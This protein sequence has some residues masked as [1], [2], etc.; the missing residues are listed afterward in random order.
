MSANLSD[1]TTLQQFQLLGRTLTL[2]NRLSLPA[3]SHSPERATHPAKVALDVQLDTLSTNDT[4]SSALA[5]PHDG[6]FAGVVDPFAYFDERSNPNDRENALPEL[7]APSIKV[8]QSLPASRRSSFALPPPFAL[9]KSMSQSELRDTSTLAHARA[10]EARGWLRASQSDPHLLATKMKS[11]SISPGPME[12][13]PKR[14][15]PAPRWRELLSTAKK[16]DYVFK[17]DLASEGASLQAKAR[18]AIDTGIIAGLRAPP[19]AS[20]L[21]SVPPP[22]ASAARGGEEQ[23]P[24]LSDAAA[25]PAASQREEV[26]FT[27]KVDIPTSMPTFSSPP[28]IRTEAFTSFGSAATRD[29]FRE[30]YMTHLDATAVAAERPPSPQA[31]KDRLL[32]AVSSLP[33]ALTLF[34]NSSKNN[35]LP[36]AGQHGAPVVSTAA[37]FGLLEPAGSGRAVLSP[38]KFGKGSKKRGLG[39]DQWSLFPKTT[40][41][42]GNSNGH[43]SSLGSGLNASQP[44]LSPAKLAQSPVRRR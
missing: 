33:P 7:S 17:A 14:A 19:P 9:L 5:S 16:S 38:E 41:P 27:I 1:E 42:A 44:R 23:D 32:H 13:S 34:G 39:S 3:K 15:R 10:A 24:A 31:P 28:S 22:F 30:D 40:I 37:T 4:L 25:D 12:A 43:I 20:S 36:R 6:V 29:R 35:R 26:V 11:N 2:L 21:P 8:E 18:Q